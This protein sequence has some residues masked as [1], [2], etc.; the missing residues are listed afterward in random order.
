MVQSRRIV[1]YCRKCEDQGG[2]ASDRIHDLFSEGCQFQFGEGF[3]H[4]VINIKQSML[5]SQLLILIC[6]AQYVDSELL[7]GRMLPHLPH[8]KY[9]TNSNRQNTDFS[10]I[11][12]INT[13][14]RQQEGENV[15]LMLIVAAI[16][17]ITGSCFVYLHNEAEERG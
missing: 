6:V 9:S 12:S 3:R 15:N 7:T 14:P 5:G 16:F 11:Q 13:E 2:G 17:I 10:Y 1:R 8:S 4:Y